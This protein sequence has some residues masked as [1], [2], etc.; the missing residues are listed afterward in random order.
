VQPVRAP[1]VTPLSISTLVA[2]VTNGASTPVAAAAVASAAPEAPSAPTPEASESLSIEAW[3]DSERCTTCN[4]CTNANRKIFAYND[5]KQA[6]I[7]DAAAGTF[8]QLVQAAEKCP[9][10]AIHPG[11]PL[12]PKEK[13]LEKWLKRAQAF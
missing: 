1:D 13:D 9:V 11:T 6:Y 5:D 10:A 4:E 8:A 3:I 7:K 12:N 2:P